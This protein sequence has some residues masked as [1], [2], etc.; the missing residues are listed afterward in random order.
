MNTNTLPALWAKCVT[1][2]KDKVN[3]R[4]FWEAIEKTQAIAVE[5]DTLIIGLDFAN[6]NQATHI[7]QTSVQ[8][9]LQT[10]IAEVFG[11]PLKLRLIEGSTLADWESVKQRD[12]RVAA[13]QHSVS[14]RR[15]V[16]ATQ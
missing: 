7:Q 9:Q 4:S 2:L 1:R 13:M 15:E 16:D 6:F 8:H 5:Q 11:K 14:V 10:T 12:E 3:N